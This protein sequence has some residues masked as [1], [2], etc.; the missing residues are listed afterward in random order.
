MLEKKIFGAIGPMNPKN[1]KKTQSKIVLA[2]MPRGIE[3]REKIEL[4]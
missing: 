4:P 2:V 1:S 3:I